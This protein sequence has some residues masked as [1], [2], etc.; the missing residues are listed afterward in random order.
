LTD[1]IKGLTPVPQAVHGLRREAQVTHH[2]DT[3]ANEAID[4]S[5]H[6]RISTL[7]F[8]ASSGGLFDEFSCGG[9]GQ[10]RTTLVAQKGHVTNE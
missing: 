4:H 1:R 8:H 5:Q 7:Q 2:R 10:I 9:H 6:L 3:H